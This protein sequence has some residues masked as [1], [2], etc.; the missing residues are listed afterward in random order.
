LME[1]A[2][3]GSSES[4]ETVSC[5]SDGHSWNIVV[6]LGLSSLVV[7]GSVISCKTTSHENLTSEFG[8]V[9]LDVGLGKDSTERVSSDVKLFVGIE[10]LILELV[11]SCINCKSELWWTWSVNN[12]EMWNSDPCFYS[13]FGSLSLELLRHLDI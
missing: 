11:N 10:T 6:H 12:I 9:A 2:F 7:V 1:I 13:L 4:V 5:T 3:D 8:W